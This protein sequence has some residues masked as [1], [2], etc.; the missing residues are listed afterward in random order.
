M[1]LANLFGSEI[2]GE[3]S[4]VFDE[5]ID[6]VG[7]RIDGSDRHIADQ[8][9][10][11]HAFSGHV[12]A[13]AKG[14]HVAGLAEMGMRNRPINGA[15]NPSIVA[16]QKSARPYNRNIRYKRTVSARAARHAATQVTAQNQ[17]ANKAASQAA[18]TL[19]A[20]KNKGK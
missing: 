16:H 2:F 11:G 1:E 13:I 15:I 12:D 5:S 8:H 9:V 6:V 18:R 3:F 4:K 19:R 14:S 17:P 10:F 20:A 7:V